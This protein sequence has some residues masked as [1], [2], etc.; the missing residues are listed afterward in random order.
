[1]EYAIIEFV[2]G[3]IDVVI[4][5]FF[6]SRLF[7]HKKGGWIS[8][9]IF[10]VA[11]L[12]VGQ[13]FMIWNTTPLVL[14]RLCI[15]LMEVVYC[16][17][18]FEGKLK[19]H[20]KWVLIIN[21]I[22]CVVGY[23]SPPVF[24]LF[25]G[26][27]G[28]D[29]MRPESVMRIWTVLIQKL[30]IWAVFAMLLFHKGKRL[31]LTSKEKL[32]VDMLVFANI[33]IVSVFYVLTVELTRNGREYNGMIMLITPLMVA[34][35]VICVVLVIKI[36]AKNKQVLEASALKFQLENQS[37]MIESMKKSNDEVSVLRHDLKHYAV[38]VR[39]MLATGDTAGA[40]SGLEKYIDKVVQSEKKSDYIK[41]NPSI[42]AVIYNSV[43]K[44]SDNGIKC[45]V[46]IS[47]YYPHSIEQDMAIVFAN[48]LDNAIRAEE[49]V[50]EDRRSVVIKIY[51]KDSFV[52]A[53]ISN[54]IESSVLID[55]PE[56]RTSKQNEELHGWGLRSAKSIV[57][58]HKG[59]LD[60]FEGKSSF[61]VAVKVKKE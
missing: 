25:T 32:L 39:D 49:T 9:C 10:A 11:Y 16:K 33:F 15:T 35:L 19:E 12:F 7:E 29:L 52:C 27:L 42:N 28:Y 41:E 3:A 14:R 30:I 56:L 13:Y 40:M 58:K 17:V 37:E 34:V 21:L 5:I 1:M 4:N 2:I 23:I 51:E 57:E 46:V 22:D 47:T 24:T 61:N 54:Y 18:A 44:C 48:L 8:R 50:L 59:I 38:V 26:V 20:I 36:S 45:D 53:L 55:N 43:C 31:K 60:V 6:L